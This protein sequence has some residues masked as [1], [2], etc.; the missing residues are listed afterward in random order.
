MVSSVL[1]SVKKQGTG[2]K[3]QGMTKKYPR[4]ITARGYE[5]VKRKKLAAI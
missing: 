5:G 2:N 1:L 3:G 4:Q